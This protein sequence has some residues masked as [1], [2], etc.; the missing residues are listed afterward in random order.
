[1]LHLVIVVANVLSIAVLIINATLEYP[2][3]ITCKCDNIQ[4][5]ATTCPLNETGKVSNS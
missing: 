4:A 5:E 1:M 2:V 3:V